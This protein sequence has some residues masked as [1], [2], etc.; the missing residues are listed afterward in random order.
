MFTF[1][2]VKFMKEQPKLLKWTTKALFATNIKSYL[3]LYCMPS[4]T[5]QAHSPAHIHIQKWTNFQLNRI[6]FNMNNI[7]IKFCTHI[8]A[9]RNNILQY[10]PRHSQERNEI[11]ADKTKKKKKTITIL[12]LFR[13]IGL[14]IIVE[15]VNLLLLLLSMVVFNSLQK[16]WC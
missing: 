5:I 4:P 8:L 13:N 1:I 11:A 15:S 6:P 10:S 12:Y 2:I 3:P 16:L 14:L 7:K 9:R